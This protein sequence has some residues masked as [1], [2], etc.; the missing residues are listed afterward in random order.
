M[1]QIPSLDIS[2]FEQDKAAFINAFHDAYSYWGFAGIQGHSIAPSLIKDAFSS[3]ESFFALPNEIKSKY[4]TN[5]AGKA[6][7]YIPF[8][9]E[10]AKGSK[11]SDLKEFYHIGREV[12]EVEYLKSNLWP[13]EVA[14]FEQSFDTLFKALDKLANQILE[15]VAL[16]IGLPQY[17]F[18][19][20][21]DRGEALLRVLHYPPIKEQDIPNLRAAAHEDINLLTLLVGSEQD[22]LQVL[23]RQGLFLFSCTQTPMLN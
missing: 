15:V 5:V 23:S 2:L 11:H 1:T 21:V 9:T 12:P 7:G 13:A 17:Y 19:N 14:N 16:T 20:K 3:A 10:K 22:G 18:E 6:R 8:G 4:E